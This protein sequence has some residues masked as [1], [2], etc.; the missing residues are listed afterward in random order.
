MKGKK[1][2]EKSKTNMSFGKIGLRLNAKER[3]ERK[4]EAEKKRLDSS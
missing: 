2:T 1:H 3:A 4:K